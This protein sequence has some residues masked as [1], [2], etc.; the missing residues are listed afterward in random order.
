MLT[1]LKFSDESKLYVVA[2]GSVSSLYSGLSHDDV[3]WWES[4]V[5]GTQANP[6]NSSREHVTDIPS[7][8]EP[9]VLAGDPTAGE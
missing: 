2:C 9:R 7:I 3:V 4:F 8:R 6:K 1:L 5:F